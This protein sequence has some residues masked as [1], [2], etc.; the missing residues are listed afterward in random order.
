MKKLNTIL[1]S[2]CLLNLSMTAFSQQKI[3]TKLAAQ[4]DSLKAED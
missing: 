1:L 2:F 4:I 3:N